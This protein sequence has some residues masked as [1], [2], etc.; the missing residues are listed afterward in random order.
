MTIPIPDGSVVIT[1]TEVY[2]EMQATHQAVQNVS[3]KLDTALDATERRLTALDGPDGVVRDHEVRLRAVER[4]TWAAAGIASVL[5]AGVAVGATLL[6]S[7][8]H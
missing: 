1:P 3:T 4:K 8:G 7:S 5:S 6:A 2:R